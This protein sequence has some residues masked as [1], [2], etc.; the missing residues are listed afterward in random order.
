MK[1]KKDKMGGG[2]TYYMP[3]TVVSYMHDRSTK[4]WLALSMGFTKRKIIIKN[5]KSICSH[6]RQSSMAVVSEE[7][8]FCL[9]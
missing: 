9:T 4:G 8:K 2:N 6:G 3:A 5:K 1:E 7:N